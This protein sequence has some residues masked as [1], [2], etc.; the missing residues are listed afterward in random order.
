MRSTDAGI[1]INLQ[2]SNPL[3]PGLLT[4]TYLDVGV[5]LNTY[6]KELAFRLRKRMTESDTAFHIRLKT[7]EREML[8]ASTFDYVV[9]N[10]RDRLD[11]AIKEI[12]DI[13]STERNRIPQRIVKL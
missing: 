1:H 6:L 7:A 13:I 8:K 11:D 12:Q 10:H 5:L 2:Y 3:I 9:I 4:I